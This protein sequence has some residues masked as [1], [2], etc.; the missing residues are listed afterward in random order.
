MTDRGELDQLWERGS[1]TKGWEYTPEQLEWLD[2][3]VQRTLERGQPPVWA[4][5][6]VAF[7]AK[8]PDNS[9]RSKNTVAEKLRSMIEDA[10]RG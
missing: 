9:P 3:I 1:H 10:K 5:V 7:R 8:W 2:Q 6:H 4:K